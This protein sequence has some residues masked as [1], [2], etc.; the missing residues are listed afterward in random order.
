MNHYSRRQFIQQSS[1]FAAAAV[2]RPAWVL[3][4]Q[5]PLLSFSTLGCPEWTF[6]QITDFAVEHQ[7]AGIELRGILKELDLTKCR[8]FNTAASRRD[9]LAMMK[10]KGLRFADLGSSATL[11]FA[12][13]VV[14]QKNREEGKRFIDL[15]NELEC[16]F[17]RVFPN[18]FPPDQ[19]KEDT[20]NLIIEGLIELADYAKGSSV[21]VLIESHGDLV[22]IADL[23]TVMH[24]AK[25]PHAGMI[26]DVVN[27]WSVTKEDPADVYRALHP[28]IKH[29]HIKDEQTTGGKL[30]Y[31]FLGRGEAPIFKAIDLL[32]KN[33]YKG[34]YSFEWEKLWHPELPAPELAI[35]D[36]ARVMNE[37]FNKTGNK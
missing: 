14:R 28:Y 16:P 12:D 3:S 26:W 32:H 36:Y 5:K 34:Y 21:T 23:E 22:H 2:I 24:S 27:M 13:P 33:G 30:Q 7:Y 17:I 10:D 4:Q 37:H 11:H 25:H 8:E 9:T 6:A 1:F 20:L 15:A 31:V 19:K 18:I 35:A 29:T